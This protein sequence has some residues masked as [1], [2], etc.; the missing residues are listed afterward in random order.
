LRESGRRNV[1][2][3]KGRVCWFVLSHLGDFVRRD[4]SCLF[5]KLRTQKLPVKQELRCLILP[6]TNAKNSSIRAF[7]SEKML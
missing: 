1:P 2:W 7:Q 5:F 4:V 6:V 3:R